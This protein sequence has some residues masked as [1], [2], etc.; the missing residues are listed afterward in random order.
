MIN[1]NHY[2]S[3]WSSSD[4]PN[5]GSTWLAAHSRDRAAAQRGR[6]LAALLLCAFWP[7]LSTSADEPASAPPQAAAVSAGSEPEEAGTDRGFVL[8]SVRGRIVWMAEAMERLHGITSVDEA[9]ERVIALETAN[10]RLVPLVDDIRG[11]AFRRDERL[12]ELKDCEL[13]VRHYADCPLVQVIR[14]FSYED[15]QKY[16]LDYFCEICAITMFE[17]K[18]CDCCQGEIELRRRPVEQP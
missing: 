13:L 18:P 16:E 15:G 2:R 4:K 9:A 6:L 12:R 1:R 7:L 10:G 11:R 8:E 3:T 5:S 14:L 17:L